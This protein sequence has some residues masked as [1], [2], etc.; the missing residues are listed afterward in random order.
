[1][2]FK[3]Q[4]NLQDA[5]LIALKALG[6]LASDGE[7]LGRF[8]ALTGIAPQ[9]IRAAA[10]EPAFLLGILDHLRGDQSLLLEFTSSEGIDP[11]RID[12][13]SHLLSGARP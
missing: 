8:L 4:T 3:A 10:A 13:A 11:A 1:M 12:A 6:F 5:E 2:R 7:R 9:D